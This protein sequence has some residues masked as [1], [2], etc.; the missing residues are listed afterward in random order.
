L[1]Q[2]P[3]LRG[4]V[5]T[6]THAPLHRLVS[7]PQAQTPLLHDEPSGQAFAQPPQLDGSRFVSTQI[8]P[9]AV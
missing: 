8:P 7:P 6:L 9:H 2:P 5:S 4:S 3:Q 1:A